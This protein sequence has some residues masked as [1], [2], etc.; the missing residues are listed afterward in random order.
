MRV[1]K[2]REIKPFL[3][4][5][6]FRTS[7]RY[8][9]ICQRMCHGRDRLRG[10]SRAPLVRVALRHKSTAW[11]T[12]EAR[13]SSLSSYKLDNF[14]NRWWGAVLGSG[15]EETCPPSHLKS[16]GNIY[17]YTWFSCILWGCRVWSSLVCDT[18]LNTGTLEAVLSQVIPLVYQGR[19]CLLGHWLSG[20]LCVYYLN[21]LTGDTKEWAWDLL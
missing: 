1:S 20:V 13:R 16:S 11:M 19:Y 15:G 21:L 4:W 10:C 5:N 2:G 7:W 6:N 17:Q 12:N 18:T 3:I 14:P 8:C 9:T